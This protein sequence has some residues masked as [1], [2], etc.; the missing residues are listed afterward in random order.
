MVVECEARDECE[1]TKLK[2]GLTKWRNP[3]TI[4]AIFL[5][6]GENSVTKDMYLR[7]RNILAY[8]GLS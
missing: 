1:A 7:I 5:T 6:R 2:V 8:I 4:L 3:S